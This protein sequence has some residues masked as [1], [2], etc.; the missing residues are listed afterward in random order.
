MEMTPALTST[1]N[2]YSV[3][4]GTAWIPTS[5]ELAGW[6][7]W[8]SSGQSAEVNVT[9]SQKRVEELFENIS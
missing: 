8:S 1:G 5:S 6:N 9:E 2:E 4:G 3:P 7:S